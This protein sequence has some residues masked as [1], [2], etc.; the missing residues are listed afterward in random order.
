M[1]T[2]K[3]VQN[4]V[5]V[6][7]Y[8]RITPPTRWSMASNLSVAKKRSAKTPMKNGDTIAAMAV[9]M[10]AAPTWGA[11]KCRVLP[12]DRK[13]TRLNSSHSQISYAVFCLKKKKKKYTT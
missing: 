1:R 11:L 7:T 13:S 3:K 9:V 4:V 8:Q 10:Y 12:R 6:D 2:G 5:S